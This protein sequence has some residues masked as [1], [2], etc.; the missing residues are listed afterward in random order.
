MNS[1]GRLAL[2]APVLGWMIHD[3]V[4]GLPDAKYYFIANVLALVVACVAYFG[5]PFVITLAVAAAGLALVSLIMLTAADLFS[6][7][8]RKINADMRARRGE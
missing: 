1:V 5:Y 3:A 6:A 2:R 8:S 4:N 7:S